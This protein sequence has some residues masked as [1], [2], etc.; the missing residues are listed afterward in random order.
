MAKYKT[1]K[2]RW[3]I[4]VRELKKLLEGISPNMGLGGSQARASTF[5]LITTRWS[6]PVSTTMAMSGT[7]AS[8]PRLSRTALAAAATLVARM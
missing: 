5:R 4:E 8:T 7:T 3:C 6:S 2:A 1:P